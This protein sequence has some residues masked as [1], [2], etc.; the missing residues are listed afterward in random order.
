MNMDSHSFREFPVT[1]KPYR[2]CYTFGWYIL[3]WS[4]TRKCTAGFHVLSSCS[5]STWCICWSESSSLTAVAQLAHVGPILPHIAWRTD[6]ASAY[7]SLPSPSLSFFQYV[8]S[9]LTH[10]YGLWLRFPIFFV[11]HLRW[12]CSFLVHFFWDHWR[13]SG[14]PTNHSPA[15]AFNEATHLIMED[16]VLIGARIRGLCDSP[17]G[18]AIKTG[19]MI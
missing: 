3:I 17:G 5:L 7:G 13:S 12:W 4:L 19:S 14:T 8:Y 9:P 18:G 15:N 2:Y 6:V 10:Y 1:Q 16:A 11:C